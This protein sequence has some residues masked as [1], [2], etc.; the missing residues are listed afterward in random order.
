MGGWIICYLVPRFGCGECLLVCL[1]YTIMAWWLGIGILYFLSHVTATV[2]MSELCAV[3][4]LALQR[5]T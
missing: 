3:H 4:T 1:Q 5:K 2:N